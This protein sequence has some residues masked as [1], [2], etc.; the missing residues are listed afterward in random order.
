MEEGAVLAKRLNR[1]VLIV[2][3]SGVTDSFEKIL[4]RRR[5]KQTNLG[6]EM[7]SKRLGRLAEQAEQGEA[8]GAIQLLRRD[9]AMAS[10]ERQQL[11]ES[12][13]LGLIARSADELDLDHHWRRTL[14][15]TKLFE[16]ETP[17]ILSG[18]GK[19]LHLSR[20][21]E[22]ALCGAASRLFPAPRGRWSSKGA[23]WGHCSDC[24][25]QKDDLA[26]E[27]LA[28]SE[29]LADLVPLSPDEAALVR[30]NLAGD[31]ELSGSRP[32]D[33]AKA[34]MHQEICACFT[35]QLVANSEKMLPIMQRQLIRTSQLEIR[36]RA[37]TMWGL[38]DWG[39]I[40]DEIWGEI[41][42]F[43]LSGRGGR[44]TLWGGLCHVMSERYGREPIAR[45]LRRG[46]FAPLV[47][48]PSNDERADHQNLKREK[49]QRRRA[50][51]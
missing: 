33:Q 30:E 17:Y 35:R 44:E 40:D 25:A 4:G 48:R 36:R 10:A 7:H 34:I 9:G 32:L 42:H 19:I 8:E 16:N 3:N 21:G 15:S 1:S 27:S 6:P 18:P 5:G 23:G 38:R 49:Q 46:F 26:G 37:W 41:A 50:G 31:I 22:K 24:L 43:M 20:G 47:V 13:V 45:S 2:K 39:Q 29:E 11:Q 51:W 14:A 28:A 12:I